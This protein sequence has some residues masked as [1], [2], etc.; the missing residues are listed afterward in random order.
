MI[1]F[2]T[3][4]TQT[5]DKET[6]VRHVDQRY[7]HFISYYYDRNGVYISDIPNLLNP[8]DPLTIRHL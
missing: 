6:N 2:I 8:Y 7:R 1:T 5:S 4:L 3:F